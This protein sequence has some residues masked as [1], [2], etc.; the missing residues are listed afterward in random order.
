MRVATH[1]DLRG[2]P[3][4]GT[5][6]KVLGWDSG[7]SLGGPSGTPPSRWPRQRCCDWTPADPPQGSVL[8]ADRPDLRTSKDFFRPDV[9]IDRAML[10]SSTGHEIF[11]FRDIHAAELH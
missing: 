8:P 11:M 1:R 7:C 2:A 6:G 3:L 4:I 10:F 9:L 5:G